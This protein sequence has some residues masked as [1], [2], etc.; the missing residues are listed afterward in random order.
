VF[1]VTV[2]GSETVLY[3]FQGTS[4]GLE[5]IGNL[6]RDQSG[7]L[8][9]A[10]AFGGNMADCGGNG[11]GV[12][13]KITPANQESVIYT[14]QGGADGYYP[15]GGVTMDSGGNLYG[16]TVMGGSENCTNGCGTVFKVT[17]NGTKSILYAFQGGADGFLPTSSVTLDASGNAYGTTSGGSGYNEGTVFKVSPGGVEMVLY[18]FHGGADGAIPEAGLVMD[19]AGNFYGTTYYG[20]GTNCSHGGCGTVFK[21][22]PGGKETVLFA[23]QAQHGRYPDA[24]LLL[25]AHGKLYGTTLEGGIKNSGVVFSLLK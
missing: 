4:D 25:A 1:E 6:V 13:F 7:N 9:G 16:T 3:S 19:K 8:Y 22:T 14:F 24:G 18:A 20:G 17:P 2:N 5:P 21:L 12:V 11:C 15:Y 10:T 23:F